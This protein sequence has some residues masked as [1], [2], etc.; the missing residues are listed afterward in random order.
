MRRLNKVLIVAISVFIGF[1][2]GLD[3]PYYWPPKDF[4]TYSSTEKYKYVITQD[5]T[6]LC[7]IVSILDNENRIVYHTRGYMH[8]GWHSGRYRTIVNW[9]PISEDFFVTDGRGT[10]DVYL[11]DNGTWSGPYGI[12]LRLENGEYVCW[13]ALQDDLYSPIDDTSIEYSI[14]RIPDDI[15]E[16]LIEYA[17]RSA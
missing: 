1:L 13:L 2:L 9:S 17:N 15:R 3:W 8:R 12:S 11:Y 5:K 16:T 6:R 10:R 14:E 4:G 7:R